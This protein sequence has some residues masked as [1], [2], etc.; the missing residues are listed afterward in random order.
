MLDEHHAVLFYP[1]RLLG[2][3]SSGSAGSS[4]GLEELVYC[5]ARIGPRYRALWIVLEEYN[6]TPRTTIS[7]TPPLHNAFMAATSTEKR[8]VSP[9]MQLSSLVLGKPPGQR[10]IRI[11]PY[12]GPVMNGLTTL[13]SWTTVCHNQNTWISKLTSEEEGDTYHPS[14]MALGRAQKRFQTQILFASDERAAARLVRSI[15]D[16]ILRQ[17]QEAVE[18]GVRSEKDGWQSREEWLWREWL[19]EQES[20]VMIKRLSWFFVRRIMF[21]TVLA[22]SSTNFYHFISFS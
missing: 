17:I 21:W 6:W 3:A 5:I 2:Q 15:G 4:S 8:K 12:V 10:A 9:A 18:Q 7:T 13:L 1:L 22:I 16:R 19:N 14:V 11:N 20:T